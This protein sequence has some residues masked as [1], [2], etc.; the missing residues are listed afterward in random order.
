MRATGGTTSGRAFWALARAGFR[1]FSTY[2]LA[3]LAGL[4]TNSV[5]GVIRAS[6]LL[7]AIAS[8]GTEIAG[9]TS[10]Q[11][12]SYVWWGQGL[13]ASVG[14]FGW[15]ELS[16]RVKSGDIA[17]DFARPID[18]QLAFLAADLGRAALQLLARGLPSVALGA[19]LFGISAPQGVAVAVLGIVSLVLAITISFGCRYAVN[20]TS[21]WLVEIRGVQM[22][23]LVVSGF[24]CGLFVPVHWFP[25]WLVTV[26]NATPFPS[27]LQ[28]PIDLL[29]GRAGLADAPRIIAVQ[30]AW[31]A[32]LLLLGQILTR[33]GRRVLEVQGG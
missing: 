14:L 8:A 28:A 19:L 23:Y 30:L 4:T 16:V 31:A 9:Y 21:F 15:T 27:M 10:A 22:F 26:A 5:F 18:P 32:G 12:S 25:S 33:R 3:T 6:I 24:L 17:V 1:R 7:A 20:L 29:R 2:R 13:I 11:A